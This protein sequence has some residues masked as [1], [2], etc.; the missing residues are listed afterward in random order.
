MNI[1]GY[2]DDNTP[3]SLGKTEDEVLNEIKLASDKLLTWF[4]DNYMKINPDKFHLLLSNTK[5]V[6]INI[7]NET[8][9]S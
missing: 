1:V 3:Y 8:I 4:Q 6:K 7:C 2:A 5:D 9:S